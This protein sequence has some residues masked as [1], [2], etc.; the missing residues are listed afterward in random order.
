MIYCESKK[1]KKIKMLAR[2]LVQ[3]TQKCFVGF[4]NFEKKIFEVGQEKLMRET[5]FE[6]KSIEE[7]VVKKKGCTTFWCIPNVS[8]ET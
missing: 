8:K 2:V 6:M 5:F 1:K 7:R 3:K 4:F